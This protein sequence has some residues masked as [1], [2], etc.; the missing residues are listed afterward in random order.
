MKRYDIAIIGS[1]ISAMTAAVYS[2]RKG[3][4]TLV[5]TSCDSIG[6]S[7]ERLKLIHRLKQQAEEFGAIFMS[8]D[9]YSLW[10]KGADKIIYTNEG[11][12]H[13]NSIILSMGVG[14]NKVGV[15]LESVFHG[16]GLHYHDSFDASYLKGK[17]V[18][19]YGKTDSTVNLSITVSS[20]CK[21]V[22]LVF[23]TGSL[24][25]TKEKLDALKELANIVPLPHTL[26]RNIE[27]I[28]KKI[29]G[30]RIMDK[31]AGNTGFLD[32]QLIYISLGVVPNSSLCFPYVTTDKSGFIMTDKN[33]K[34]NIDGI[35]AAGPICSSITNSDTVTHCAQN[36][37]MAATDGAIAAINA[38]K[39]VE[40]LSL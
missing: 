31:T 27:H 24:L 36:T 39:Y 6:D 3:L 1:D 28:D 29:V 35:Y 9:I 11:P 12:V 5:L 40:S 26:I 23:P 25:C 37:T 22:Y 14:P 10:H 21:K 20:L 34:T 16:C 30:V 7:L 17:T 18:V 33:H 4:K 19:V 8:C 2:S 32:C 15:P 38:I 13:A